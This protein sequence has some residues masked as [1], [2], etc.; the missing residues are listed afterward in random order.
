V[1][2]PDIHPRHGSNAA[3]MRALAS[4]VIWLA[5]MIAALFGSA[6]TWDWPR[7]WMFFGVYCLLTA[8][9][10]VWL[11]IV[12][13]E[14][15]AARSKIQEGTKSWDRVLTYAIILAFVAILP[16]AAL[17]DARFRW[18]PQPDWVVL[19]G[20]LMFAPGFMGFAWAQSVNR[21]FEATVRIQTDRG[22]KVIT[23]GPYAIVRH[24]GYIFAIFMILGMALALGSLY[25]LIPAGI[26]V[27]LVLVRTLGEDATLKAELPG[28]AEYAARVKQRWIPGIW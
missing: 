8:I 18:A 24:P 10:C 23:T 7:G 21:N 5:I 27:L 28:Y 12:N 11:W 20:Y 2:Q 1:T 26:L 25:A 15:F 17:D 19:L 6:G 16:V 22:H 9:A 14:I 3:L 13:P 4:L